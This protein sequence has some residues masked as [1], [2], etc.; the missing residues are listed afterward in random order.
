MSDR[1]LAAMKADIAK[2]KSDLSWRLWLERRN[3]G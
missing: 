1:D 3:A 2:L